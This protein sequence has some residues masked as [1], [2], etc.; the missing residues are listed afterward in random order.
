MLAPFLA[1]LGSLSVRSG[2]AQWRIAPGTAAPVDISVNYSAA[3]TALHI[4]H[5]LRGE[6]IVSG[7]Q[8][9]YTAANGMRLAQTLPASI[10]TGL[11]RNGIKTDPSQSIAELQTALNPQLRGAL[12]WLGDLRGD[13]T[14]LVVPGIT[15]FGLNTPP[16]PLGNVLLP[17]LTADISLRDIAI[18]LDGGNFACALR[19]HR[20]QC[21]PGDVA[22]ILMGGNRIDNTGPELW[23]SADLLVR[24][25]TSTAA[26]TLDAAEF[27]ASALTATLPVATGGPFVVTCTD[28][29]LA[30]SAIAADIDLAHGTTTLL[31]GTVTAAAAKVALETVGIALGPVTADKFLSPAPGNGLA[32]RLTANG[33]GLRGQLSIDQLTV[34][35]QNPQI[36]KLPFSGAV[37]LDAAHPPTIETHGL[38]FDLP[39]GTPAGGVVDADIAICTAT[40][41]LSGLSLVFA[42]GIKLRG[43]VSYSGSDGRIGAVVAFPNAA[44]QISGAPAIA[45]ANG[46]AKYWSEVP[47]Q[48]YGSSRPVLLHRSDY[49]IGL[50]INIGAIA[51]LAPSKV[52]IPLSNLGL[53]LELLHFL[54]S[55]N[56]TLA[57]AIDPFLDAIG[58]LSDFGSAAGFVGS[59]LGFL[60]GI[61]SIDLVIGTQAV[62]VRIDDTDSGDNKLAFAISTGIVS[63]GG[64][65]N[66]SY[67][68]PT[69]TDW[70]RRGHGTIEQDIPIS[71]DFPDLIVVATLF[72]DSVAKKVALTGLTLFFSLG[73]GVVRQVTAAVQEFLLG[74]FGVQGIITTILSALNVRLPTGLPPSWEVSDLE[75]AKAGGAVSGITINLRANEVAFATL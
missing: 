56:N 43:E 20:A 21:A 33:T 11:F 3:D 45:L 24:T 53:M 47:G 2:A 38:T 58:A 73:A 65:I 1:W 8:L 42:N 4:L 40:M 29:N 31:Q 70:G 69:L 66:Y 44:L 5:P 27:H 41:Q 10:G 54:A 46:T 50:S 51:P 13:V 71:V 12:G 67:P 28:V 17:S 75:I 61:D 7:R 72:Y 36:T 6:L 9:N 57:N 35:P 37:V 62:T 74:Y 64:A 19:I 18:D 25:G 15:A 14:I 39:S 63:I 68:D 60:V 30:C 59:A 16:L 48:V 55:I 49:A 26:L 34:Q 32:L 23:L 22:S 52:K